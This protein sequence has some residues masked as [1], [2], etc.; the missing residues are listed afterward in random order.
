MKKCAL[1]IGLGISLFFFISCKKDKSSTTTPANQAS[2]PSVSDYFP[3]K[4]GN[5]WAYKNTQYDT[6]G[7]IISQSPKNDSVVVKNDTLINGKTYF[8]VLE[9]NFSS[10]S[11]PIIQYYADS[12][13]CIV[14]NYGNIVFSIKNTTGIIY[15]QIYS[16]DT[17]VYVNYSYISTPTS[18]TVPL[19]A[20]SCVNF[21]GT[22]YF[23]NENFS[24]GYLTPNYYYQ[25]IGPIKRTY[26]YAD[27]HYTINLDLLSYHVQ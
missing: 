22:V 3:L 21:Q 6:S 2:T 5:Y 4:T 8:T 15:T 18:V 11:A 27:S 9:Y 16:P 19:G 26:I 25:N 13:D 23:K 7:N 24:K 17:V 12:A 14:N 10:S 20:Y 1:V